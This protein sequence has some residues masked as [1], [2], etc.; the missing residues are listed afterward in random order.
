MKRVVL[1]GA[2]HAHAQV[3]LEFAQ[4]RVE[5][6][7][8][9]SDIV[10]VSPLDRAP[11]SGMVP[12]WL[13]G[14]YAW[15]ECCLDFAHLCRRAGARL[16]IDTATGIDTDRSELILAGGE[17][18]GYDWLSLNVGSTLVPPASEHPR[19]LPMRP[20][21]ALH[22]RWDALL[23]AVSR[24]ADGACYRVVM[25]GGGP[26]GVESV[27]AAHRRLTQAAPRVRF[28]LTLATVGD[29]FLQGLARSTARLLRTQ[30]A[31]HD[32]TIVN[33][34]RA[35]QLQADRV[36][37]AD[38]RELPADAVLWATG[39]EAY[40]WL[41]TTALALDAHGFV[42]IDANLRSLSHPN[43][44]AVGDCARWKDPLPKSGVFAVRMGPV[45][46]HN[47]DAAIHDRPL[48]AYRP[49]R[50][51]LV[52]IGSGDAHAVAAWGPLGWQGEWVWQWK[53]RIDRAF[54]ARYNAS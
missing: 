3:L 15:N 25:I 37:G 32:I 17:R 24:L 23:D 39:A 48:K 47:L 8:I 27:L 40:D 28:R 30:L 9:D 54:V 29:D 45:L 26:A 42:R 5:D 53:Q 31:R 50:R 10:L 52:L 6:I 46:A 49:Q 13:A 19:V 41:A 20:L 11:Y 12:G 7:D 4:R 38:G 35:E 33:G 44:F 21:A 18:I 51:T 2:G 14:H 16:R 43:I 36:V 22:A 1:V 34:Y